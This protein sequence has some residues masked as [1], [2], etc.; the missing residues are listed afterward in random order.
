MRAA[1]ELRA[2]ADPAVLATATLASIQGGLVLTQTRRDPNQ[3]RV[4]LD[5]ART[6]LRA[7]TP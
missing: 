4:A 6:Y 2:D 1:G 7:F 5:A 3:L